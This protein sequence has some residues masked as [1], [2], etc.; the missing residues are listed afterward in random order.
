MKKTIRLSSYNFSGKTIFPNGNGLEQK[1]DF[2]T[3]DDNPQ[4]VIVDNQFYNDEFVINDV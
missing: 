2:I 4:Y 3:D 1:Y